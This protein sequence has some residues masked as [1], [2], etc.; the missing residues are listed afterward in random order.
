MVVFLRRVPYPLRTKV[1]LSLVPLDKNDDCL[2]LRVWNIQQKIPVCLFNHNL[3]K[4]SQPTPCVLHWNRASLLLTSN[5]IH[6]RSRC[7]QRFLWVSIPILDCRPHTWPCRMYIYIYIYTHTCIHIHTHTLD[8]KWIH[9][10][11]QWEL[12]P[13][14]ANNQK[15]MVV[16]LEVILGKTRRIMT[17][18]FPKPL[19]EVS[20]NHPYSHVPECWT[21]VLKRRSKWM[22]KNK[23]VEP[24]RSQIATTVLALPRGSRRSPMPRWRKH[25]QVRRSSIPDWYHRMS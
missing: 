24:R 4:S 1:L 9:K 15:W 14:H 2:L 7:P 18:V 12:N 11:I 5:S 20:N 16:L 21:E 6:C 3:R 22:N 23:Y 8:W 17:S 19:Q 13:L 25:E 10:V